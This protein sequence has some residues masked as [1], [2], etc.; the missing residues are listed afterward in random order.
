MITFSRCPVAL[1]PLTFPSEENSRW[2]ATAPSQ[3]PFL[4]LLLLLMPRQWCQEAKQAPARK[5]ESVILQSLH[6]STMGFKS[7][8]FEPHHY[9][10]KKQLS[11]VMAECE[12][13]PLFLFKSLWSVFPFLLFSPRSC[14]YKTQNSVLCATQLHTNMGQHVPWMKTQD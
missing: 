14:L 10:P 2:T 13:V 12:S 7:W 3:M 8:L 1:Y 4:L 6:C 5:K 9:F 11:E